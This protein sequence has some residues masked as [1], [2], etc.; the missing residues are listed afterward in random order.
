[1]GP[2]I[3]KPLVTWHSDHSSCVLFGQ[4][5]WA[6]TYRLLTPILKLLCVWLIQRMRSMIDSDD[7]NS[8]IVKLCRVFLNAQWTKNVKLIIL[9]P[10]DFSLVYWLDHHLRFCVSFM[11]EALSVQLYC[12]DY[13]LRSEF[14]WYLVYRMYM[15]ILCFTNS[16][17]IDICQI[18]LCIKKVC[19]VVLPVWLCL[20]SDLNWL[21]Y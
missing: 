13:A 7:K 17:S 21:I 15:C 6:V 2:K 20:F 1:M 8:N 18:A 4:V 10:F 16:I 19:S 14:A 12:I 11:Q 3:N 9:F 5:L